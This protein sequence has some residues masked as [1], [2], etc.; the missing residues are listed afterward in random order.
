LDKEG[1]YKDFFLD[2][3]KIIADKDKFKV[4]Y[5][6]NGNVTL[7]EEKF[8]Q[9]IHIPNEHYKLGEIVTDYRFLTP[10]SIYYIGSLGHYELGYVASHTANYSDF[11][12]FTNFKLKFVS[13]TFSMEGNMLNLGNIEYVGESVLLNT[14]VKDLGKLKYIGGE[15]KLNDNIESL[16]ML[17]SISGG[18]V[19]TKKVKD[20]GNLKKIGYLKIKECDEKF[21]LGSL[22][23]I[24]KDLDILNSSIDIDFGNL[25]T[26]GG[27]LFAQNTKITDLKNLES[28]GG[29]FYIQGSKIKKFENLKTIG[30]DADFSNN[31]V[32]DS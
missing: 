13:G 10:N 23:E 1:M 30:G 5:G 2:Y 22:E 7:M 11:T 18:L 8:Q 17:E 3:I 6:D 15:L 20:L 21:T 19:L 24:E 4:D 9:V 25:K 27:S 29:N 28:V 31:L 26:I 14:K 16:S 12:D 32:N